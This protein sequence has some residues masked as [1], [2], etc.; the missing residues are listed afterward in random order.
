MTN[1]PGQEVPSSSSSSWL[2][3]PSLTSDSYCDYHGNGGDSITFRLGLSH[4]NHVL[5]E[6]SNFSLVRGT[7]TGLVVSRSAAAAAVVLPV[8]C[9]SGGASGEGGRSSAITS[10]RLQP[11]RGMRRLL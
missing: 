2:S 11:L 3:L 8:I 9:F 5:F 10:S 6:P 1:S 4:D 7:I